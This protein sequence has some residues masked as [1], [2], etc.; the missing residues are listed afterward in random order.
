MENN[1]EN[2]YNYLLK[3]DEL[4]VMFDGMT[5]IWEKDKGMFI[6][7]QKDMENLYILTDVDLDNLIDTEQI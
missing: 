4:Y 5:G 7:V 1:Y 2:L 6:K 3:S